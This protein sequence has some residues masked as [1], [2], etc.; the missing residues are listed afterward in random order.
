MEINTREDTYC[1][2]CKYWVGKKIKANNLSGRAKILN[3]N[4][5]C[6]ISTENNI[7]QGTSCCRK[8]ERALLYS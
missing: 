3:E 6:A 1:I 8:F 4:G 2:I 7:C 5:L